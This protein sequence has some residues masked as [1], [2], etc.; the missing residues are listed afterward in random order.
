MKIKVKNIVLTTILGLLISFNAVGQNS[1]K[2]QIKDQETGQPVGLANV[3]LKELK[4]VKVS[5]EKILSDLEQMFQT[6]LDSIEAI[7]HL[8]KP[9]REKTDIDILI[10]EQNYQGADKQ[11]IDNLIDEMAIEEP[12]EELLSML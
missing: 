11:F 5:D 3:Q 4:I 2:G 8:V 7:S 6:Y 12:L 10:K 9:M 1:F